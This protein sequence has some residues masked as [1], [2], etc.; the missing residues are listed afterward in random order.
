[1]FFFSSRRRHTR[2]S[3]DWS[4]DVCS[5]DLTTRVVVAADIDGLALRALKLTDDGGFVVA[6]LLR[7]SA[8]ACLQVGIVGLCGECLRPVQRQVKMTA[9]VVEFTGFAR[10]RLVRVE[11]LAVGLIQGFREQSGLGVAGSTAVVVERLGQ[12]EELT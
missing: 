1:V 9:A 10:R 6:Q 8:K 4:S 7:Q 5:S 11:E 12:R 3:R 2:F